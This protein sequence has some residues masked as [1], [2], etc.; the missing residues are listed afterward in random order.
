[1]SLNWIEPNCVQTHY[2]VQR[3]FKG[4]LVQFLKRIT[5]IIEA[6]FQWKRP[7]DCFRYT[8]PCEVGRESCGKK[9]YTQALKNKQKQTTKQITEFRK[10]FIIPLV[11][12]LKICFFF[13]SHLIP[14]LCNSTCQ[15]GAL[16]S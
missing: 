10:Q 2:E 4:L 3:P 15:T 7:A 9:N 16:P 14:V 5:A 13:K 11:V 1:M 6:K 12:N 8:G